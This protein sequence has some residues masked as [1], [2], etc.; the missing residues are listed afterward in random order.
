MSFK[1]SFAKQRNKKAEN[2][3]TILDIKMNNSLIEINVT[4]NEH[5]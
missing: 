3:N 4:Q 5:A 2:M 1:K